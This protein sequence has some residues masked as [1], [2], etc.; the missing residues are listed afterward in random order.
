MPHGAPM[1]SRSD[2]FALGNE[3]DI[4]L[5]KITFSTSH[6]FSI[7]LIFSRFAILAPGV[8][9][10]RYLRLGLHRVVPNV[11]AGRIDETRRDHCDSSST[12]VGIRKSNRLVSHL[13]KS[14]TIPL[15]RCICSL[16]E[17]VQISALLRLPRECLVLACERCPLPSS[18][19][20]CAP[21]IISAGAP[22]PITNQLRTQSQSPYTA[23]ARSS[24]ARCR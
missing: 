20:A 6:A 21:G 12:D 7:I 22:Y 4:S 13:Q 5:P 14:T 3:I 8:T 11:S 19:C 15:D 23:A 16:Q 24:F 9:L 2:H 10:A 1:V 17:P 18:S